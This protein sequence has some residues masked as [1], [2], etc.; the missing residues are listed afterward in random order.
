[1]GEEGFLDGR[2][3]LGVSVGMGKGAVPDIALDDVLAEIHNG[4]VEDMLHG[5][6][7][8]RARVVLRGGHWGTDSAP[9]VI[10]NK[11]SS[12]DARS[13][14]SGS[15][16]SKVGDEL[17]LDGFLQG[18][19][20]ELQGRLAPAF[21]DQIRGLDDLGARQRAEGMALAGCILVHLVLRSCWFLREMLGG[22]VM[23]ARSFQGGIGREHWKGGGTPPLKRERERDWAV[24]AAR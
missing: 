3:L 19:D 18:D 11:G 10:H 24:R 13:W 16:G 22:E 4:F 7:S 23:D 9:K 14:L 21:L 20:L 6:A 1:M 2:E 15:L 12:V 5:V 17:R 8:V